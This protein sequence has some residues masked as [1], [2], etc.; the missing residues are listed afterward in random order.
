M[1]ATRDVHL[2]GELVGRVVLVGG[3]PGH[4]AVLDALA[5]AVETVLL[6]VADRREVALDALD[7][8][9]E[10]SLLYRLA[11]SFGGDAAT[12]VEG[13]LSEAVRG[14]RASAA[15]LLPAGGSSVP[16]GR[17]GDERD[18]A[19][20]ETAALPLVDAV[21][22]TRE[23]RIVEHAEGRSV[24]VVPLGE[25]GTGA[26]LVLARSAGDRPFGSPDERLA[27]ALTGQAAN[28][29]E[30]LRLET[31]EAE[32]RRLE[33]ELALGR[34]IQLSL[35]PQVPPDVPGWEFAM[36]YEAAREVGG[37]F[38]DVFSLRDSPSAFALVMADV[39]GKGIAAALLM[40]FARPL[41][42]A[43]TDQYR[44]PAGALEQANRILV[45]ERPTPLFITAFIAIVDAPTGVVR[46]ASAGHEPPLVVRARPG[47]IRRLAAHGSLLGAFPQL[48]ITEHATTLSPGDVLVLHTD[49]V[50]DARD[51]VG[52][53]FGDVRL[54]KA[55]GAGRG[56]SAAAMADRVTGAVA[57]FA[58]GAPPADDIALL[59][60]RRLP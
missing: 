45:L 23:P 24:L 59:T 50:T 9:R 53:R 39:T 6:E 3:S 46:Y 33:Q 43:I 19:A 12:V 2:R 40:A 8:Y 44:S 41:L 54:G 26:A 42:R 60:A 47:R 31:G 49:G 56:D 58:S 55:I 35:L 27:L 15:A 1:A 16:G 37:D 5:A 20:A 30:R 51:P 36:R 22:L 4:E 14:L 10:L 32:R 25:P 11:C 18:A 52:R 17:S 28:A 34:R 29:L 57:A 48:A 21:L 38:Y 13:L 7:R